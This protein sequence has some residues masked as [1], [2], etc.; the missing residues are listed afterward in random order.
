MKIIIPAYNEINTIQALID[1]VFELEID[2]Q[3]I[4]VDDCL[5]DGTNDIIYKNKNKIDKIIIHKENKG[6]GAA[7]R[8]AQEHIKGKYVVIQDADLEY[9]PRDISVY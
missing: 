7:I 3:I 8:S 4:L 9:D 6:K 2:K 5:S 1:K